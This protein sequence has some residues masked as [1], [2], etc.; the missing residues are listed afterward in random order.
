MPPPTRYRPPL[1]IELDVDIQPQ[2]TETT[3]GPTCLQAVYGFHGRPMPLRRVINEV[4]ALPGGG[5]F[6]AY[7]G[8]HSLTR[9]FRATIYTWNLRVFDPT[10]FSD[11]AQL[12]ERL[13]RRIAAK[14]KDTRLALVGRAYSSFLAAGGRV[15]YCDLNRALLRTL[16]HSGTPVISG[17]SATY[18]YGTA[19]EYGPDDQPD[20]IRGE[21]AGHFVVLSGYRRADRTLRV[22]DPYLPNPVSPSPE[23]WLHIDR[24]I[25]AILLGTLT[26]DANLLLIDPANSTRS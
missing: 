17:L 2:P 22:S 8:S 19:R 20:D 26:Y 21:P 14:K 24:V 12:L 4:S 5:T 1:D 25:N 9:G 13:E 7:L 6:M 23:Y 10:W 18:L 11:R 16:L 15:R 3:C